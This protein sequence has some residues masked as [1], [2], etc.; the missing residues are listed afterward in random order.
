MHGGVGR[1]ERGELEGWQLRL[2]VYILKRSGSAPPRLEA[3]TV[4]LGGRGSG[5]ADALFKIVFF[6]ANK[7]LI[8]WVISL[9]SFLRV[10]KRVLR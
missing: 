4:L 3:G 10:S 2:H 5:V 8:T 7:C 9:H 1:E 6:P